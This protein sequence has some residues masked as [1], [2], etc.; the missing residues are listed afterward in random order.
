VEIMYCFAA[1]QKIRLIDEALL[2]N[3]LK[4]H[5]NATLMNTPNNTC[6]KIRVF[7]F[8]SHTSSVVIVKGVNT[9]NQ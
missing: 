1:D 8:Y 6:C 4:L 7:Y 2:H 9:K 3:A 5:L